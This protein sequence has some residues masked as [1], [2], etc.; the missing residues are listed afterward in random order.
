MAFEGWGGSE[1]TTM[2][3]DQLFENLMAL[4]EKIGVTVSE[5]NL[6]RSGFRVKSGMCKVKGQDQIIIDKSLSLSK[7]N[8]AMARCLW[9]KLGDDTYILP[10]VRD[11]LEK[12]KPMP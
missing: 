2:K 7:K 8:S 4:A 9:E 5:Q 1:T 11:F 10:A 3:S 12:N 6:S